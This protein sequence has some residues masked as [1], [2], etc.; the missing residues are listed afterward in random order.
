MKNFCILLIAMFMVNGA[1][2]QTNQPCATCLP[3][4]ITFSTQ[5]QINNFQTN[6]PN[7]TQILGFV[8]IMGSNITNLNGLSIL[9]S[10]GGTLSI[11]SNDALTNL[12]GLTGLTSLGG[13]GLWID[14]NPVL[15]SLTGLENLISVNGGTQ[16]GYLS[17]HDNPLLTDLAGLEGLTSIGKDLEI[18]NNPALTNLTGLESLSSIGGDLRI[19]GTTSLNSL[20]GLDSLTSLG[21]S[22]VF[23]SNSSLTS[24][25]ALE[26]LTTIGGSMTFSGNNSLTNFTGLQNLTSISRELFFSWNPALNSLS[27]LENIN[28]SSITNLTILNN[29]SLSSCAIQ[30]ICDYLVSPNGTVNISNNATG[31][32]SQQ[33]IE[34][35]CAA[36]GTESLTPALAFAMYPNPSSTTITIET[37]GEGLISVFNIEGHQLLQQEITKPKTTIDVSNLP[38]GVYFVKVRGEQTMQVGKVIKE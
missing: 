18:Y 33:E 8:K 16:G 26:G 17:I 2:G 32:N 7:C 20:V 12:T 21:G 24:L 6:Y 14:S 23:Y 34:D 27:G 29:N 37:T 30:S 13:S 1:S 15:T 25:T 5:S 19:E 31:C 11:E 4:G 38:S 35:A 9:A 22:L 28:G 10:I 36:I 3:Q